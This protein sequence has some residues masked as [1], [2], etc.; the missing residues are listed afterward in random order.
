MPE[1]W[2]TFDCFGTLVDWHTG[3][4]GLLAPWAGSR[5]EELLPIYHRFEREEEQTRPHRSYKDVLTRSTL[6]AARELGLN[7]SPE[8]ASTLPR[9]WSRLPVFMDVEP[10]LAELRKRGF[11][12]GVLTNCDDDLFARTH[13]SFE[14]P[15]DLVIT[16]ERVRDYK[17]SLSHFR[18]F[19]RTTGV[20]LNDWIHVACSWYHDIQPARDFGIRRIWLDRDRT[21]EDERAATVRVSTAAEVVAVIHG[22]TR[23]G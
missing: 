6:R 22:G 5:T 15:F 9:S 20:E 12:L 17:P 3:F 21:G 7:I 1:R 13:R 8:E 14:R 11:R 23:A 4:A 2:V 16:A 18:Y 19:W 10:M